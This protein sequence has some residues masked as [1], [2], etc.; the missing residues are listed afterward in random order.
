MRSFGEKKSIFRFDWE[1]NKLGERS[2]SWSI[3]RAFFSNLR[4]GWRCFKMYGVFSIFNYFARGWKI[5]EKVNVKR[6]VWVNVC[7]VLD[8]VWFMVFV[9]LILFD[10]FYASSCYL[11]FLI[12]FKVCNF[13][14]KINEAVNEVVN[15]NHSYIICQLILF[16]VLLLTDKNDVNWAK[17]IMKFTFIFWMSCVTKMIHWNNIHYHLDR[18]AF[19]V[20]RFV[21]LSHFTLV[22]FC[23]GFIWK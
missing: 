12:I 3:I 5:S 16:E 21:T 11:V 6:E 1:V 15:K 8:R 18:C 10:R 22:H 2:Y 9:F 13:G 7:M 17:N 19:Y 14:I 20:M 23:T 4:V